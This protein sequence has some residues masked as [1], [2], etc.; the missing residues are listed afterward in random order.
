MFQQLLNK[1]W[2]WIRATSRVIWKDG[3]FRTIFLVLG[4][5]SL[6][7]FARTCHNPVKQTTYEQEM[8]TWKS[9]A[10]V[11]EVINDSLKADNARKLRYVDSVEKV[12]KLQDVKI[13]KL[14]SDVVIIRRKNDVTLTHLQH[15][16]PD[17]CKAA[18]DLAVSYRA[19]SDSNK[20]A[21]NF[22]EIEKNDLLKGKDSLK[23]ANANLLQQNT[24]LLAIIH[25]VPEHKSDKFLHIF[26][27]PSR[28]TAFVGG[29]VLGV[30]TTVVA[31]IELRR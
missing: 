29:G 30:V 31:I 10:T 26:P 24:S 12:V 13:A 9:R 11:A 23:I 15:T 21:L 7:Y 18:L 2:L 6:A 25:A 4:V 5:A 1:L 19:E 27:L 17:T 22:V 16:L 14:K 28:T 8:T 20:K 3:A